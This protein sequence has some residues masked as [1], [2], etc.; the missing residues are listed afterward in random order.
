M[1]DNPGNPAVHLTPLAFPQVFNLLSQ[2]RGVDFVET[3]RPNQI[4]RDGS[5]LG[6]IGIVKRFGGAA[7]RAFTFCFRLDAGRFALWPAQRAAAA[8]RAASWRS[9][10]VR[11][12]A[13][14]RP[15]ALPSAV[16]ST[17]WTIVTFF[18]I[19]VDYSLMPSGCQA[20]ADF[21]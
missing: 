17:V 9:F 8:L 2:V 1:L 19:T 4:R 18:P 14:A 10:S 5:P 15:P 16:T 12:A 11:L 21:S 6:E 20:F 3:S 7:H 13:V